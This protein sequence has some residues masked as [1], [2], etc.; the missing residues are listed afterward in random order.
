MPTTIEVF[1]KNSLGDTSEAKSDFQIA[2]N[3]V[4][5]TKNE[6]LKAQIIEKLTQEQK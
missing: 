4:E 3:L 2:L 5:K 6:R 1:A